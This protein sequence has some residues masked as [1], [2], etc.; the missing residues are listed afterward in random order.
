MPVKS[1]S[2][3]RFMQGVAHGNI[4]KPGLSASQAQEFIDK[5]KKK[6]LPEKAKKEK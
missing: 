1:K 2:Q 6:K 3:M 5:T 4:K